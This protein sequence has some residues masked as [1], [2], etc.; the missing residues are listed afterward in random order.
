MPMNE[1]CGLRD[2]MDDLL[3]DAIADLCS[4]MPLGVFSRLLDCVE[5]QLISNG[6]VP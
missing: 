4:F 6:L 2:Q 1:Q 3:I 5:A